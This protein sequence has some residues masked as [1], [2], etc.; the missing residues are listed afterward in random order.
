MFNSNRDGGVFQLYEKP[1]SGAGT[2]ELLR[3]SDVSNGP[4]DWSS[5][6]R[7]LI[8][9]KS[10][11]TRDI[12]V[13][14]MLD[15]GEPFPFLEAGFVEDQA[16]LSPDGRWIAYISDESGRNEV[17]VAN[18]PEAVGKWQIS[19]GGGVQPRWSGD[20]TELFYI[21][22]DLTIMAVPVRGERE[23]EVGAPVGLF[24]TRISGGCVWV[25]GRRAQYDVAPGRPVHDD[26]GRREL[27]T[28]ANP[29]RPQLVS[30]TRA[31]RTHQLTSLSPPRAAITKSRVFPIP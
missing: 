31:S 12:W 7:F 2:A 1:A 15:E 19:T 24:D 21:A 28:R 23:L 3:A 25:A 18:F 14:P 9:V 8:Y 17:Y 13:L 27:G 22:P 26:S 6:G 30:G 20:G 10:L 11:P 29:C 16:K 4:F 5:D